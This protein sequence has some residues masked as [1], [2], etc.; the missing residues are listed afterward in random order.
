[1]PESLIRC[2]RY[3][4]STMVMV[5]PS[6]IATT[7]PK[8]SAALAALQSPNSNTALIND[9]AIAASA[10]QKARAFVS[11]DYGALR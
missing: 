8:S 3:A 4:V 5:S 9:N 10:A 7:F 11:R 1:M 6:A 2:W